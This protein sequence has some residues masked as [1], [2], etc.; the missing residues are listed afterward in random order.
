M[1]KREKDDVVSELLPTSPLFGATCPALRNGP[2][3]RSALLRCAGYKARK[4]Q[5]AKREAAIRVQAASRGR[6]TRRARRVVADNES[7]LVEDEMSKS[8]LAD[9][10]E[11]DGEEADSSSRSSSFRILKVLDDAA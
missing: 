7:G 5:I 8:A 11:E 2:T 3:C 1:C 4:E 9:D 10:A 6:A